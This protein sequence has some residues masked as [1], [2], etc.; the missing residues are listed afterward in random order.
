MTTFETVPTRHEDLQPAVSAVELKTAPP[1]A[2]D[3]ELIEQ[4]DSVDDKAVIAQEEAKARLQQHNEARERLAQEIV[5][6]PNSHL[7]KP[8]LRAEFVRLYQAEGADAAFNYLRAGNPEGAK[9]ET[10]VKPAQQPKMDRE[11]PVTGEEP[12]PEEQTSK[13]PKRSFWQ[14]LRG[15]A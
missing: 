5:K 6:N 8:A 11:Q 2:V 9:Q 15:K 13:P 4:I 10:H 1:D 12:M 7:I 14:R 3:P